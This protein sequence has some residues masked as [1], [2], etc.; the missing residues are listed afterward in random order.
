[1][2]RGVLLLHASLVAILLTVVAFAYGTF[3]PIK[4]A[5]PGTS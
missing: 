4:R 1:M 5:E 2:D 3:V